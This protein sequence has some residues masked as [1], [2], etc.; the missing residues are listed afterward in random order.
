MFFLIFNSFITV[1]QE[2][3][4]WE[5]DLQELGVELIHSSIGDGIDEKINLYLNDLNGYNQ[6]GMDFDN[7]VHQ[8]FKNSEG[9]EVEVYSIPFSNSESKVISVVMFNKQIASYGFNLE[10]SE[11]NYIQYRKLGK[12]EGPTGPQ[13]GWFSC[14]HGVLDSHVGDIITGLGVGAGLGCSA[15]GVVAGALLGVAAIG[16]LG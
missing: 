6:S 7:V 5:I 15:C 2:N 12:G 11:N 14:M 1:A 13:R 9:K 4:N 10:G 16:C 8:V 3:S